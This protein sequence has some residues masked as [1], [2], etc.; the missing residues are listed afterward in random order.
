MTTANKPK[1][2]VSIIGTGRLGTALAIAL[3]QEGYSIG[4]LV[5]RH[6][7]SARRAA[8]LLDVSSRVLAAKELA[9]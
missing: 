6:R 4:A 7:K 5:A 1:P 2:G 8:V 9:G 3:A